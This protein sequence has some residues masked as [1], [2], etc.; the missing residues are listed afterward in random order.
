MS[1]MMDAVLKLHKLKTYTQCGAISMPVVHHHG[2]ESDYRP[3]PKRQ[4]TCT[5]D[6]GH[7]GPHRDA[8]CCYKFQTFEDWQVV[9]R[10]PRTFD[11]CAEG[12]MWPCDTVK[13][14]QEADN[15]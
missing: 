6:V 7:D 2:A 4:L 12:G 1:T 14:L 9:D 5:E 13:A 3:G 15:D 11:V 10:R 8:I